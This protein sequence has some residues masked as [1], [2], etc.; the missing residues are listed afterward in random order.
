MTEM[1]LYI[2]PE[3]RQVGKSQSGTDFLDGRIG[4]EEIIS[5]VGVNRLADPIP[6]RFPAFLPDNCRQV[7]GRNVQQ[8]CII[9]DRVSFDLLL[10]EKGYEAAEDHLALFPHGMILLGEFYATFFFVVDKDTAHLQQE[11]MDNGEGDLLGKR[12]VVVFISY[13]PIFSIVR[14]V[15]AMAFERNEFV[16]FLHIQHLVPYI[17]VIMEQSL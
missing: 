8:S 9:G 10:L 14:N 15:V 13:F 4:I 2:F 16:L 6:H 17:N 11:S 5:D 1:I 3:K 12:A 7:F